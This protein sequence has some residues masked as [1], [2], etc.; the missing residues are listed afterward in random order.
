[1]RRT[2][3]ALIR[4]DGV[5]TGELDIDVRE[6][7]MRDLSD[8]TGYAHGVDWKW[9]V[10]VLLGRMECD[11]VFEGRRVPVLITGRTVDEDLTLGFERRGPDKALCDA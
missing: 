4:P 11:L 3:G 5:S 6:V 7:K 2:R 1:M 8:L 10:P 9:A